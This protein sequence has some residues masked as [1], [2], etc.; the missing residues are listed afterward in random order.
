MSIHVALNHLTHYSY[1]RLI[2]LG[3]QVIRLR[4]C[5]HSRT[6]IISYS[7]KVGPE[8]HFINWQQD[9]QGNY[10]ARLVFPEKTREFRF[11]VDLVAEM[12]VINPFDFFLEPHAEKIPFAYEAWESHELK[13]YLFKLPATPLFQKYLDGISLEKTRSVDFLVALNARLQKDI[14][15]TIRMEAGVQT[16]EETLKKRS[17]SCRDSAWLLVQILRH[18]GLASRFVSGYLIQL[19]ADVKSLDGPSGPEKDFTDLHAWCE[20]YLPGAGWIGLDPTSGLF[21]G[22]G[23][24]PLACTP[25]P[26]SAAPVSG[27]MDKCETTFEHH[28]QVTRIWEAPRVTKPYSDAQWA[29]IEG[30]GHQIDDTLLKRDVRLTQGGE[31]TF[32]AVNDPDGAEWNTAALG[33][34][35]RIYAAELFHRL[36]EKY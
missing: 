28:M 31:P 16:P 21:A 19:T 34:T 6:R 22:E 3:P 13:P 23:H 17:G 15:Y 12:S 1:D 30:L 11:E 36:R 9:P 27:G 8:K 2:N 35:K 10:L 20:V 26:A 32:V 29:E 7:L 33:P 25:Q 18:L 4:P 24:I 5:P 14:A